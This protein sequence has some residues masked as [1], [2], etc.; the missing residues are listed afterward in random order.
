MRR[1]GP[2]VPEFPD[3]HGLNAGQEHY[4]DQET[5]EADYLKWG[6][7]ADSEMSQFAIKLYHCPLLAIPS[8]S[9]HDE[10]EE[11]YSQDKLV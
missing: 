2:S 6:W 10:N 4:C 5:D 7:S 3:D 9:Q 1:T 8:V 11:R